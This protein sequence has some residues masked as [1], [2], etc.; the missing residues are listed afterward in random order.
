P[1][2]TISASPAWMACAAIIADCRPEPQTLFTVVAGTESGRPALIAACRAGFMPSPACR[3]QPRMTSSTWS[4]RTPLRRT[5]S[6]TATVP[7]STAETSLN[8]P[9]K[10]PMAVRQPERMTTSVV[11]IT[12]P[13]R[14]GY[15]PAFALSL[16]QQPPR[17][18]GPHQP[19]VGGRDFRREVL[20]RRPPLVRVDLEALQVAEHDVDDVVAAD[21]GA[22]IV[23]EG[24]L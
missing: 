16:R 7:S 9:P 10:V 11:L 4:G 23:V 5:A 14:A 6:R 1:A 13:R 12:D 21:V 3:M 17:V 22:G 20:T 18:A 8:A 19:L 15:H 24:D 2:T